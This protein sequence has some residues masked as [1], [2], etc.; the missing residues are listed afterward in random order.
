MV[1][2]IIFRTPFLFTQGWSHFKLDRINMIYIQFPPISRIFDVSKSPANTLT[3]LS[4]H[5]NN[6]NIN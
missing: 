2:A 4:P 5:I 6:A 3:P 1:F